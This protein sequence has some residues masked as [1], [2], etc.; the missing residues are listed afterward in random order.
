[1]TVFEL[2][3][4][5]VVAEDGRS[6]MLCT[7]ETNTL[8]D[9]ARIAKNMFPQGIALYLYSESGRGFISELVK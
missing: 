7:I 4:Y 9:A 1:M 5:G 8:E 3:D 6:D 2:Y